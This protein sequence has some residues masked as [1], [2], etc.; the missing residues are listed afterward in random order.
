MVHHMH[1]S[2]EYSTYIKNCEPF[3]SFPRLAIE[4][5]NSLLCFTA[6]LSSKESVFSYFKYT[7]DTI[8]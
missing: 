2:G 7:T 6:K 4:R 5:R 3:V 1:I 8:I